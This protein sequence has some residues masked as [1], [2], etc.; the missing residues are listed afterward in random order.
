MQRMRCV[1]WL[2][3]CVL[4][5]LV[6]L[7]LLR[8]KTISS[9]SYI[10]MVHGQFQ[11]T[12]DA[13]RSQADQREVV[14][15]PIWL[16]AA[17]EDNI[18]TCV[19]TKSLEYEKA[20]KQ[21]WKGDTTSIRHDVHKYLTNRS[22]V[23]D[24]GGN[25][26]TDA[27]VFLNRYHARLVIFE[28]LQRYYQKLKEK[29]AGNS[30]VKILD[31]GLGKEDAERRLEVMGVNGDASSLYRGQE[32]TGADV[33][34]VKVKNTTRV[35]EEIGLG[36]YSID[37]IHVDCEGCEMDVLESL[38]GTNVIF[39]LKHIQFA[40]HTQYTGVVDLVPRYCKLQEVLKRT[41]K[42]MY[43]YKFIWESWEMK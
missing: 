26:G 7:A 27:D 43:Q 33:E 40:T 11:K 37:L 42:P 36:R 5:W 35:L 9:L 19:D 1:M 20:G 30:N 12:L 41:H 15:R 4:F 14:K 29:F 6:L 8:T 3:A 34:K 23:L 38:V 25:V 2:T 32:P 22:I 13:L 31:I 21:I 18:R 16:M 39:N 24:I 28:P 10:K 17:E